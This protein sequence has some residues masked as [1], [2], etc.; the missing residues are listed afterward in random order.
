MQDESRRSADRVGASETSLAVPRETL[1]QLQRLAGVGAVASSVSHEFN[2][3]L[4][5]ILNQAKLGTLS[6]DPEARDRCFDK[7][8]T[9]ARRHAG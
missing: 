5:T 1:E 2:N 3:I 6:R 4:T 9:S 8:L 7:I